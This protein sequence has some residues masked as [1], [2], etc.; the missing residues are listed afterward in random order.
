M[1]IFHEIKSYINHS[2][3][4]FKTPFAVPRFINGVIKTKI[5]KKPALRVVEIAVNYNC[6][7]KCIM[8]SC[9][10]LLNVDKEKMLFTPSEYKEI[11]KTLTKLG[12]TTIVITGGEPLLRN[13]IA[14]VIRAL[15]PK[16]KIISLVTNAILFT[17][18]KAK[19]LKKAGLNTIEFSIE[20]NKEE[21]NDKIRGI[22]GHFKKVMDGIKNAKE[23]KLNVCL[24]PTLS[25]K[26][27]NEFEEFIKFA[28]ELD[29][30]IFLSLA[31][32]VGKWSHADEIMLNEK[33]WEFM[34]KLV[35]KY[36]FIRNDFN[37]NYTLKSGCPTGREKLYIS[38]YGDILPCSFTHISFGNIKKESLEDIW[39]KMREFY[40]EEFPY[41]RRIRD[42]EY[43]QKILDPVKDMKLPLSIHEHPGIK[44]NSE[45]K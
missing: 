39:K 16:N 12:V 22:K 40:K 36:S 38:P 41:C 20:S 28:K 5:F 15:N 19:E 35:K 13:D 25:H 26:N 33:D 18:D 7:S 34:E 32:S 42:K 6:N 9:S 27:I 8:C 44:L 29:C 2:R 24:S 30:F 31:G 17:R 4:A 3:F 45:K 23:A 1:N 10:N 37:T 14:E 11:G 43:A 21:E